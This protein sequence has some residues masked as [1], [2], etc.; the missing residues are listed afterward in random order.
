MKGG[1]QI[2]LR[3]SNFANGAEVKVGG[4]R[5]G[6]VSVLNSTTISASTGARSTGT[7]DVMVINPDGQ[8]AVLANAYTYTFP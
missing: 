4:V 3:G 7:V 1:D 8:T 6:F 2:I 5:A